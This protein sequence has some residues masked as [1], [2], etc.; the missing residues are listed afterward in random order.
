MYVVSPTEIAWSTM[1]KSYSLLDTKGHAVVQL[2]E[3]RR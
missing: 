3:A 2:V 1:R